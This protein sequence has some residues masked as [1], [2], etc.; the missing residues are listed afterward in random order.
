[1]ATFDVSSFL[2]GN[3]ANFGTLI[4][5][6]NKIPVSWSQGSAGSVSVAST[7]YSTLASVSKAVETDDLI[8][9]IARPFFSSSDGVSSLAKFR[10]Y[11]DSSALG[12]ESVC[13]AAGNDTGGSQQ[14]E[15]IYHILENVSG[16]ITWS[17]KMARS[18]GAGTIYSLSSVIDV[19]LFKKR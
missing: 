4:T 15:T 18:S 17:L 7:T 6:I 14:T 16:T 12:A 2:T 9:L 5:N 19:L 8:L 3:T 11:Q 10:F 1:M 13:K